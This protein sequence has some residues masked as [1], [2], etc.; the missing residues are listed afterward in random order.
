MDCNNCEKAKLAE[1]HIEVKTTSWSTVE[2]MADAH[3]RTVRWMGVIIVLLVVA[4]IGMSIYHNYK[5][6]AYDTIDISQDGIGNNVVGD[7][8]RSYF[9]EPESENP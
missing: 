9:N 6:S 2:L 7:N 8:N 3:K 5:W 1:E 4:M